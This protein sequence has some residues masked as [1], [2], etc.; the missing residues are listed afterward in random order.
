MKMQKTKRTKKRKKTT[1]TMKREIDA[2]ESQQ[3]ER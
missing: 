2:R 3:L 1:R